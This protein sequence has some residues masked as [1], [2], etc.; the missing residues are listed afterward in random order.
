MAYIL[1]L[2]KTGVI[3]EEYTRRNKE[4]QKTDLIMTQQ[5]IF[6]LKRIKNIC[7]QSFTL[8]SKK[9]HH[10]VQVKATAASAHNVMKKGKV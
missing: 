10:N 6:L 9:D 1:G 5:N 3:F 2:P 4:I 7:L 8:K